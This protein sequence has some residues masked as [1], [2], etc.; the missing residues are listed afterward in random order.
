MFSFVRIRSVINACER[1]NVNLP[2]TTVRR[3]LSLSVAP[4]C[5]SQS[6]APNFCVAVAWSK[7]AVDSSPDEVLAAA[8]FPS[9]V[10]VPCSIPCQRTNVNLP[11]TTVRRCLSLRVA[12][13]CESQSSAPNFCVA[14]AWSKL[15]V[16][17]SPD[18]VL[19]ACFTS[20]VFVPCS[21]PCQ[22]TN[23]NLPFTTV[24][25]CLSLRVAPDC[26]SQSSAP[27]FCVAV[28]WSK[29]A[30]DS[31]PDEVLAACFPSFVFVP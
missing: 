4:D 24:R 21:I 18:E 10:F 30:V 16:D 5:E 17:S 3:C 15:A 28:A 13:D 14:V 22:R 26:E 19:A 1:T 25:C 20:V 31:S 12:P 6:S 29:L 11:F 7:L 2:F 9:F 8:C 27:N 23:V